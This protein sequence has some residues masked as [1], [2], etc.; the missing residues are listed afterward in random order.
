MSSYRDFHDDGGRSDS[1]RRKSFLQTKIYVILYYPPPQD[2]A[3]P[4]AQCCGNGQV[5]RHCTHAKLL[6]FQYTMI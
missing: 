6:I 3:R 1:V 2:D 4:K 5:E